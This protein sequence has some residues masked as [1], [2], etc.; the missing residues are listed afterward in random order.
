MVQWL[1]FEKEPLKTCQITLRLK[2]KLGNKQLTVVVDHFE[3]QEVNTMGM[4][5]HVISEAGLSLTL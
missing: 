2:Q 5:R 3:C 1:D 4:S